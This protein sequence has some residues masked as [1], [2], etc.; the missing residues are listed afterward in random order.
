MT[1]IKCTTPKCKNIFR[2]MKDKE[3]TCP[4]CLKKLIAPKPTEYEKTID[5]LSMIDDIAENADVDYDTDRLRRKNF[6]K[7]ANFINKYAKR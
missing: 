5:A 4:K 6:E 3:D 1:N 7:V 2:G